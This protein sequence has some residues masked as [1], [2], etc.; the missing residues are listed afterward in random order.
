MI[1][2]RLIVCIVLLMMVA[3]CDNE[4]PDD[5]VNRDVFELIVSGDE[6]RDILSSRGSSILLNN[7]T[8]ELHYK[9]LPVEVKRMKTRGKSALMFRRKS[10]SVSLEEAIEIQHHDGLKS[11]MLKKFKLLALPQDYTYIENRIAFG[12]ME[13]AG[14]FPLIYKY[15]ELR[16]N[17]GT[18]GIYLL[19]EDPEEYSQDQGSEY[20][21]RRGYD[22]KI[23]DVDYKKQMHNIP[24]QEYE[25]RFLDLY[26][27]L[28]DLKGEELHDMVAERIN[29]EQYFLKMG[30]DFLLKNGDYTDETFLYSLVI[31]DTIQFYP[32]PWDYD[33]IFAESPHEISVSWGMGTVYGERQYDSEADIRDEIGEKIIYSIEDDLDYSIAMDP[34][35]YE[36]YENTTRV[37]FDAIDDQYL[38]ELFSQISDELSPYYKD[39]KLVKMSRSDGRRTSFNRWEKNM[40]DK[41]LLLQERMLMIQGMLSA[42]RN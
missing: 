18:Q 41:H 1:Q 20:I 36:Q 5:D 32:I 27:G 26:T 25:D 11:K 17:E 23:N 13:D 28:A 15:V 8:L 29:L 10:F 7:K 9:G 12:I 14:I 33:D 42:E 39:K 3:S 6:R 19:L 40:S 16:L 38:N 30:I 21:L 31:K 4:M 35:F 22:H 24:E 2:F 37:F 34:Y